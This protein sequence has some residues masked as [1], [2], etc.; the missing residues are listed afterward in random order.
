MQRTL[1]NL[2][3]TLIL[4]LILSTRL[5]AQTV[6]TDSA[7]ERLAINTDIVANNARQI[8]ADKLNR[9]LNGQLNILPQYLRNNV[10]TVYSHGDS[11]FFKKG[12]HTYYTIMQH[13]LGF[14]PVNVADSLGKY[15]TPTQLSDTAYKVELQRVLNNGNVY[16]NG[17]KTRI[18]LGDDTALIAG[19]MY[20]NIGQHDGNNNLVVDS[21]HGL[22]SATSP[23]INLT[24][25][26]IN[27]SF[28]FYG[29]TFY[30][31][32]AFA[33]GA[34]VDFSNI[35]PNFKNY[36]FQNG[37]GSHHV[38]VHGDLSG[39]SDGDI[40]MPTTGRAHDTVATFHDIKAGHVSNTDSL[41]ARHSSY[42]NPIYMF[43][44]LGQ[45]LANPN[46]VPV[47]T[48]DSALPIL[49]TGIAYLWQSGGTIIPVTNN[50]LGPWRPF[51]LHY[52]KT[53]GHKILFVQCA[54]GGSSMVKAAQFLTGTWDIRPGNRG[55]LYDSATAMIDSALVIAKQYGYSPRLTGILWI[56]GEQDAVWMGS[57]ETSSDYYNALSYM[58]Q[59]GLH[60]KY[61]NVPFYMWRTG[62]RIGATDLTHS[63]VIRQ[64]QEIFEKAD[65]LTKIV[66]RDLNQFTYANGLLRDSVH[67]SA[68]GNELAGYWGA[69]EVAN[70]WAKNNFSPYYNPHKDTSGLDIYAAVPAN[71]DTL[72][73]TIKYNTDGTI[74][75]TKSNLTGYSFKLDPQSGSI[76]TVNASKLAQSNSLTI[77]DNSTSSSS[78]ASL[79]LSRGGGN[80][81][82][83]QQ[84]GTS[85]TGW[86]IN[87]NALN[88]SLSFAKMAG[89]S[90]TTSANTL[91]NGDP[92]GGMDFGTEGMNG[93]FS[94]KISIKPTNQLVL[95]SSSVKTPAFTT[96]GAQV[97]I[98]GA[99]IQ[100]TSTPANT[101]IAL[102]V[103]NN[104]SPSSFSFI[105]ANDTIT[106]GVNF[107]FNGPPTAGT[108][109]TLNQGYPLGV[110]TG[111]MMF[112]AST[113]VSP[114]AW[115]QSN[116]D[117]SSGMQSG[118]FHNNGGNARW[119]NG[120]VYVSL[121]QV[122]STSL[123]PGG[124]AYG[125]SGTQAGISAAGT[126]GNVLISGGTG[127][128][129]WATVEQLN[130]PKVVA[131]ANLTGQTTAG[132]V[133]TYTTGAADSSF[134]ISGYITVTAY[135][136]GS[137]GLQ[138]T[139]TD[140][141][142][143]SNTV[144]FFPMGSNTATLSATGKSN[145]P[146]MGQLRVKAS[147]T[148]TVATVGTFSA[149]L[150]AGAKIIKTP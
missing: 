11:V 123:T 14:T 107:Y 32:Y 26:A 61:V 54:L 67:P 122:A 118:W 8:T 31:T 95:G 115:F 143:T 145:F 3:R 41:G 47:T 113:S 139:Y 116:S 105:N 50:M 17:N 99:T 137:V 75:I 93:I 9:I 76:T 40:L 117:P 120:S 71:S 142:N 96:T 101:R 4:I 57:L 12:G 103:A 27:N 83:A 111:G 87:F 97:N 22:I 79:N 2:T 20:T 94:N 66:F 77:Q 10:D 98:V 141:T 106:T 25:T 140:E 72:K 135:T 68:F 49:D 133:V 148:I 88:A 53:T 36:A 146:V 86:G 108:N 55:T 85:V 59:T 19:G 45:S 56:Q 23:H 89:I 13:F 24:G 127:A 114:S 28:N 38:N 30:G 80:R 60:T 6:I 33:V 132:N 62:V 48:A 92:A 147:T 138:V 52:Y 16:T 35:I 91:A 119:Y 44:I 100:D 128:P 51:A 126:T 58:V 110:G 82:T 15:V 144:S 69:K 43:P 121:M 78:T 74:T 65:T 29:L 109:C 102:R 136:S 70:G 131:T 130:A 81:D 37:D 34:L 125:I 73:I 46:Y 104:V 149:T 150:N 7:E 129:T 124:I 112:A 90:A 18:K 1:A 134:Q 42:Y 5:H 39:T 63:A 21:T 64:Q 84:V